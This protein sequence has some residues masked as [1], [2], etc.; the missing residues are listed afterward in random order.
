MDEKTQKYVEAVSWRLIM[1]LFLAA[2]EFGFLGPLLIS[3]PST[4][5]VLAGVFSFFIFGFIVY[6]TSL[7]IY[8]LKKE[9]E[10]NA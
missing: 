5:A 8:S 9:Y 1:L 2:V 10:E 4:L 3:A 7:S 6:K